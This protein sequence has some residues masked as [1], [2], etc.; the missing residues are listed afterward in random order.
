MGLPVGQPDLLQGRHRALTRLRKA[1]PLDQRRQHGVLQRGHLPEQVVELEDE[2]HVGAP[3]PGQRRVTPP[4]DVG[5]VPEHVARGRP[6]EGAE[7]VKEGGLPHPRR[8]DDGHALTGVD[9][10]ADSP[11]DAHRLGPHAVF[12]LERLGHEERLTGLTHS[13][14]RPPDP[15][16]L[17]AGPAR[18]WPGTR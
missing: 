4:G 16:A 6:V 8:P 12:P 2:A 5:A 10:Q 1:R 14:A 13:E 17:P 15:C 11:Q 7:Q 9:G 3:E 18:S